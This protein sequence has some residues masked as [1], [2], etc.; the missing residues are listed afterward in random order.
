MDAAQ[1]M[2]MIFSAEAVAQGHFYWGAF[3]SQHRVETHRVFRHPENVA[4]IAMDI[5]ESFESTPVDAVITPNFRSGIQLAH[6]VAGRFNAQVFAGDRVAG[7]IRFARGN[8]P[9]PS[10]HVLVVD[11]SIIT[12]DS[13]SQTLRFLERIGATCIG[14]GVFVNRL[15]EEMKIEIPMRSIVSL[16]KTYPLVD[17][18]KGSGNCRL[19]LEW[20]Q[21]QTEL[22]LIRGDPPSD[23]LRRRATFEP[24]IGY[25][26]WDYDNEY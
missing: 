14:I 24:R 15:P 8:I 21:V 17:I 9:A 19:C 23:L 11:D 1:A 5:F 10:G 4:T 16:E 13:F 18:S 7:V 26:Q 25:D 3:H 20:S 6:E 12:G 2:D 22:A